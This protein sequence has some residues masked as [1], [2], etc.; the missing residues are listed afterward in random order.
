MS[1]CRIYR[2]SITAYVLGILVLD[3]ECKVGRYACVTCIYTHSININIQCMMDKL[4]LLWMYLLIY[5]Y[6]IIR[7]ICTSIALR[8]VY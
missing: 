2:Y 7:Y 8:Q 6:V 5:A 4:T 3:S 1:I